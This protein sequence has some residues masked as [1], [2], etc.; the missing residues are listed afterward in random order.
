MKQRNINSLN[1]VFIQ[2]N[3]TNKHFNMTLN[4]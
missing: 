2:I 4:V 1:G 3:T